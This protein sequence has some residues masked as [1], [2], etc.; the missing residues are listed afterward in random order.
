M[1]GRR[2]HP[3]LPFP[4]L[5]W[6]LA[7]LPFPPRE[8]C[9]RTSS[10]PSRRL[11]VMH[12]SRGSASNRLQE[13]GASKQPP[14]LNLR[15]TFTFSFALISSLYLLWVFFL[16]IFVVKMLVVCLIATT[17]STLKIQC[18]KF[19]LICDFYIG[20]G[21]KYISTQLN[22]TLFTE[23]C[24][25][26]HGWHKVLYI[27]TLKHKTNNKT[28]NAIKQMRLML[29]QKSRNKSWFLDGF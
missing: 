27:I 20:T 15:L 17:A 23:H 14:S 10:W 8:R 2:P 7:Y 11:C 9:V 4:T 29:G 3:F 12:G 16:P 6:R 1:A 18:G 25:Y 5:Q 24:K 26:S 21:Q 28:I 13:V 22:S 19:D